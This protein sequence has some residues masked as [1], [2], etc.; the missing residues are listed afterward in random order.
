M[1][2]E[3]IAVG[4][5]IL[6]GDIV[7]TN[8]Q[9]LSSRLFA[10]GVDMYYQTVA[11]DNPARLQEAIRLAFLRADMVI[12][13]G[14]LGPTEDDLTKETVA[15]YFHVPLLFH[16]DI[17]EEIERYLGGK[18][19]ASNQKQAYIPQSA[20]VLHN[21]NGTAPGIILEKEGKTAILLPGPPKELIPMFRDKVEPYLR[22]RS[23]FV[24][25]EKTL[26]LFGI[27][28]AK[29]GEV[30]ADL[31]AG[32]NPTVAPYAKE[33]EVTLRI[34]AKAETDAEAQRMIQSMQQEIE[35]RLGEYVYGYDEQDMKQTVGRLLI[36]K[37]LTIACA[38]SCT[39]GRLTA[40][41]GDV[42]G[43]SAVLSESIVTYSNEAKMKYLGVPADILAKHG[44]VSHETAEAMARGICQ[45][46]GA[47][48]GVSVTGIAG[49]N[50]GTA[51][52]P[53]GL[54][55]VGV[56]YRGDVTVL[57]LNLHGNRDRIRNGA[58]MH[59]L[60]AVRK[61]ILNL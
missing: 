37:G 58:V 28:E 42:S 48:I 5:E 1:K 15:E 41:L 53:V 9:F 4:T 49:P 10:L 2:A 45:R 23:G 40:T 39:A 46:A 25:A 24:M 32:A 7:N 51:E 50:G 13:S 55:Y 19:P 52:K 26:R 60:N 34:A 33:N 57:K 47:D 36:Q 35:A 59:A 56:C 16:K 17:A 44:A 11:G 27:G 29:V 22:E 14:G 21:D 31:M 3:I 54:V 61:R 30:V 8:A 12:F 6:V 38:E 43:I 20:M 18:C